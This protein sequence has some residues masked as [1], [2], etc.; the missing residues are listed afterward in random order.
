M[1]RSLTTRSL[2]LAIPLLATVVSLRA[3][4]AEPDTS[5]WAC[6]SC[7]LPEG[8]EQ[9]LDLGVIGV[10]D[11]AARFG[12]YTGLNEEGAYLDANIDVKYWG[13]DARYWSLTGTDLGLDSR[14][15]SVEGGQQGRWNVRA[16]WDELPR[17]GFDTTASPFRGVGS[18]NLRLPGGWVR[19]GSTKGMTAL[20]NT[21][22]RADIEHERETLGLGFTFLPW[23]RL[24]I[25]ADF[26]HEER[27]GIGIRGASFLTLATQ[28]THPLD[29]T[30][31]EIELGVSYGG[32]TWNTRLAYFGSFFENDT[33]DLIWE[34]PYNPLAGSEMGQLADAPDNDFH[35]I[36]LSGAWRGPART[37]VTGSVAVGSGE[38]DDAFLPYST[39]AGLIGQP[40]PR[41]NLDADIDTTN[42]NL[43]V[44]T[45]P[46]QRLKLAAEYRFDER[47]NGSPID[48]YAYVITDAA[49]GQT[50]M[51]TPY[52]YERDVYSLRGD[53]RLARWSRVAVGWDRDEMERDFQDRRDTETDRWWVRFNMN[54]RGLMDASVQYTQEERD[55]S[56]YQAPENFR[57]PQNPL[58]RKYNLADRDR[59]SWEVRFSIQPTE[60]ISLGVTGN[61]SEDD[62]TDSLV[63]LLESEDWNVTVDASLAINERASVYTAYTREE[64]EMIQAGSQSF[65]QPDWLATGRDEFD[66]VVFGL[67]VPKLTERLKLNLDYTWSRSVG[68]TGV[69]FAGRQSRFPDL[70]T[71][72]HTV[73][74]YLDYQWRDNLSIRAGYWYERYDTSD[75]ALDGVN[76]D[77]V[78][79][80]LALGADAFDYNVNTV[81]LSATYSVE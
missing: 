48:A 58:M 26:R 15:L 3:P 50:V 38:Q 57:S 14:F 17:F 79:N 54:L 67:Q 7:E 20:D 9:S 73:R 10:S 18:G 69:D 11:D 36:S 5:R 81:W 53:L 13:S 27:D 51:N 24:S 62:Y 68:E 8:W 31:D 2:L 47:D 29:Y 6:K 75:W 42:L 66:T 77:T 25:D 32:K 39:N 55:G 71:R 28:L 4:A 63:G 1:R 19:S 80:L 56:A 40:L 12:K 30:T 34:T 35:Q 78:S 37:T 60:R 49:P 64:I 44:T 46:W 45:S 61:Y 43:R 16:F 23:Q 65:A 21:L 41:T 70:D 52:S 76:P 72:L 33:P 59:D 74:L 22:R